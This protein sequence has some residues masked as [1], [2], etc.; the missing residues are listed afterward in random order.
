MTFG[1][2]PQMPVW[3][4][5]VPPSLPPEELAPGVVIGGYRLE[6]VVGRGGMGTVYRATQMAL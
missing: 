2:D 4:P 6:A 1:D 5:P 3:P